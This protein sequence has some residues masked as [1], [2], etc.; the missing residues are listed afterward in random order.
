MQLLLLARKTWSNSQIDVFGKRFPCLGV[1]SA[2]EERKLPIGFSHERPEVD[3][4]K[5]GR[6]ADLREWAERGR[7][8]ENGWV[9]LLEHGIGEREVRLHVCCLY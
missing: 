3:P 7:G 4:L 5:A 9:P 1:V 2:V 6:Q 8:W